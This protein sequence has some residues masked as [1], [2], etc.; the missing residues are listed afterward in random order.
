MISLGG[1]W[2]W[3]LLLSTIVLVVGLASGWRLLERLGFILVALLAVC[4]I[5]TLISAVALSAEGAPKSR[6]VTAGDMLLVTYTIRN[7][8]FWPVAWTLLRPQ[9]LS[10]LPVEGQLVS[11]PWRGSRRLDV[12]IPCP[13]RGK[14]AAGGSELHAG[15]PFGFFERVRTRQ[16]SAVVTVYPRPISLPGLQ[17]VTFIGRSIGPR[18][19][20]SPQPAASVREVRPYRSG[21][22]PS[23][24]HWL[25]T[26]RLD[27]LMVKEPEGEPA[28]HV[29]L[30]L[31]LQTG[32][33]YG[34][35]EGDSVELLVGAAAYLAQVHLPSRIATGL[36][37]VGPGTVVK[38]DS[39]RGQMHHILETLATTEPQ[40]GSVEHA[41]R[42][43]RFHHAAQHNTIVV[44]T[45][46]ADTRWAD[47]LPTL[48]QSGNSVICVLLD[49]PSSGR[50]DILDVQADQLRR[51]GV[52]TYRHTA[53]VT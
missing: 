5:A 21:D 35:D 33:H 14:W 19:A 48:A 36:L 20:P 24:I 45:T 34:Q 27:T 25:S 30:V 29:W 11:L 28:S 49:T 6:A 53:W 12:A 7:R 52:A 9:G 51:E 40:L 13:R 16:G 10:S 50:G 2:S 15:D 37:I 32:I 18:G 31:D 47:T 44:L 43:L 41:L 3:P 38:P 26:A 42:M 4:L 22:M 1:R 8:G 23:R 46:W 39:R 17:V